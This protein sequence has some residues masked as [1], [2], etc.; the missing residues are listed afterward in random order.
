M[1]FVEFCKSTNFK[2]LVGGLLLGT[3]GKAILSSQDAK[4]AYTHCTAAVLRG[5]D[6]VMNGVDTLR[7][8]CSDI[9]AGANDINNARYDAEEKKMVEEARA[10]VEA[11]DTKDEEEA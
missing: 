1:G 2:Y 4:T 9:Y 10:I 8:N 6:S 5:K 3:A 11:Y 7:E